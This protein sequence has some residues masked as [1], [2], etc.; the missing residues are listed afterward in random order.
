MS[1]C[2]FVVLPSFMRGS[3]NI[4]TRDLSP[5][6]AAAL[7]DGVERRVGHADDLVPRQRFG[8]AA[9][10]RPRGD[11]DRAGARDGAAVGEREAMGLDGG[12]ELLGQLAAAGAVDEADDDEELLAAPTDDRV[13]GAEIRAESRR[14]LH[15]HRVARLVAVPA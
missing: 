3:K 10:E 2:S 9:R 6:V 4:A 15:Q 5:A 1:V 14:D 12:A 13:R 7:L 11:A 8:R